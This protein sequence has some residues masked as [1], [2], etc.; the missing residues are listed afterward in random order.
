MTSRKLSR[1]AAIRENL[2]MKREVFMNMPKQYEP[3]PIPL[4]Q[5]REI[6]RQAILRERKYVRI[7]EGQNQAQDHPKDAA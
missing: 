2:G 4:P 5:V 7:S 6:I 3:Q 1:G